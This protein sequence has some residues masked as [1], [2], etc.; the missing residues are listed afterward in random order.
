VKEHIKNCLVIGIAGKKLAG[1][2]TLA[3]YLRTRSGFKD[4]AFADPLYDAAGVMFGQDFRGLYWQQRKDTEPVPG[5]G[6]KTLRQILQTLGTEWG[7]HMLHNDVW[8]ERLDSRIRQSVVQASRQGSA[9]IVI[10]DVR[11]ENEVAWVRQYGTLIHIRNPRTEVH[12]GHSSEDGVDPSLAALCLLN[13]GTRDHLYEQMEL[14]S[15]Q[16]GLGM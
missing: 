8:V 11:E 15:I 1:K 2:S 16:L 12:D 3:H 6:G 10:Q 14:A 7:R 9:R 5:A 13:D 4:I